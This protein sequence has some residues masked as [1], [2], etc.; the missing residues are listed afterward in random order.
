M[1]GLIWAGIGKGIADAGQTVSNFMVKDIED[2]RK[3]TLEAIRE[4]SA[5]AR[6]DRRDALA[7]ARA[8]ELKQYEVQLAN[9][10]DEA[11][12][13]QYEKASEAATQRGT[14]RREGIVAKDV[15]N[16]SA[17]AQQMA[18]DSPAATPE[19]MR[20]HLASL[21]PAE[22][23]AIEGTGLVSKAMTRN[24]ERLLEVDDLYAAASET[25]ASSRVKKDV[26]A[27]K[28]SV[29]ESI[30]SENS[31]ARD[32]ANFNYQTGQLDATN[33]RLDI[34]DANNQAKLP[35]AQQ[36]ADA[37]TKRANKP[38]SGGGG[39]GGGSAPKVRSTRVDNSGNVIAVM[40][41]GSTKDLGI[42]SGQFDKDIS[43]TIAQMTAQDSF[44]QFKNLPEEEKR[45]Q[46]IQRLTGSAPTAKTSASTSKTNTTKAAIPAGL[47]EGTVFLGNSN[48]KPVYKTPDGRQ[49]IAN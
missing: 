7:T 41:D 22:R 45:A 40:S 25:G 17:N 9:E 42:K 28:K 34:L 49:L 35:I 27:L 30:K 39:S 4:A 21:S 29:L 11:D 3:E 8:K 16:L 37:N 5:A 12:A 19:E 15:G 10:Q 6:D 38:P 33:R 36:N 18:G 48:G 24:Q 13:A 26:Q 44:G 20:A 32:Q 43:N 14:A 1:S 2:K 47:P 46:A 31:E 23:K